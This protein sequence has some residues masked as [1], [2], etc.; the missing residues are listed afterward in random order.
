[1]HKIFK[2]GWEEYSLPGCEVL[3][4][5]REV[6]DEC[7]LISSGLWEVQISKD[8]TPNSEKKEPNV[9]LGLRSY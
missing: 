5:G 3:H 8:I 4:I 1:M 9:R 7:S 6:R 2:S